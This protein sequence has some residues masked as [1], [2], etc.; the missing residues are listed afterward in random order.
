MQHWNTCLHLVKKA[1]LRAT[2]Y[3]SFACPKVIDAMQHKGPY[4][5]HIVN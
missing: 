2:Y 1:R 5:H 3:T 4:Q